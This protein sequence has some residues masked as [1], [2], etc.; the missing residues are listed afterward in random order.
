MVAAS[1]GFGAVQ[2]D[3]F[4][5]NV[6]VKQIGGALGAGTTG[7]QWVVGAYTLL[8]AA[9][10]LT[11]GAVGDRFGA[12]RTYVVGLALFGAAS[13]GC[14]LAPD[15]GLLVLGRA[16]QGVAAAVIGACSLALLNHSFTEPGR[17]AR[18]IGLWAAGASAALSAGPIVGGLLIASIGW[19]SIFFLNIPLVAVALFLTLRHTED[20]PR[21]A[22]PIDITG[23]VLAAAGL[24]ALAG[25]LIEGGALGFTD[26]LVA[27]LL[28]GGL[29][30]L[31]VFVRWE[32]RVRHP[33]LPLSYF[34]RPD[35]ASPALL[36][37]VVNI[38]FYGLIFVLSLYFQRVQGASALAAGLFF[39]P[40]TAIVLV[41]NL[42]AGRLQAVVG[43]RRVIFCGLAAMACGCAGL[44]LASRTTPFPDLVVQLVLLGGG[45]GLLV[46]PMIG[47]LMGAVDR[48]RS[49][50]ASGTLNS[51]RQSGSV[52]GVAV[53]G[54]LVARRGHFVTGFHTTLVISLVLVVIAA[55]LA[56]RISTQSGRVGGKP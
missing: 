32:A 12:R 5:V 44:L 55:G 4:V 10:I 22:H 33:M 31:A 26:P 25:G 18:A 41:A 47:T 28:A 54:S 45:L 20:T 27:A 38:A 48:A 23:Q 35:F 30:S 53:F 17:R 21:S 51:S 42:A 49:G 34:G 37:F 3:V 14:G 43:S 15:G 6:G 9:L 40:M 52:L 2:L 56:S 19:R 11:A 46:P 1:L 29:V 7:L 36:G 8:F 13:V 50:V 16:L 39:L 24:A